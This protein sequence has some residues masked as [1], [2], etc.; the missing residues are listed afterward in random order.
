VKTLALVEEKLFF[1]NMEGMFSFAVPLIKINPKVPQG[2]S[3]VLN[4]CLY[5]RFLWL[6]QAYS[7]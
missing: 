7:C 6:I 3:V 2:E 1:E 5:V 4:M